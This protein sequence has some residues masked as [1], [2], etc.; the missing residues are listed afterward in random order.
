MTPSIESFDTLR[1]SSSSIEARVRIDPVFS[2]SGVIT[3]STNRR[4]NGV[5]PVDL[6]TIVLCFHTTF[7]N[8]SGHFPFGRLKID[9]IIP[10]R[11]IPFARSTR[12]WIL[13]ALNALESNY[14]PFSNVIAFST[15]K[16]QI[17]LC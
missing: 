1:V 5:K 7:I 9:L 12:H 14:A 2:S 6:E 10:V 17:T 11:M 16:W 8:S 4:L 13:D 15:P 3:S